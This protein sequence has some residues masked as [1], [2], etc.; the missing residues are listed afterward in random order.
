MVD[1]GG[2]FVLGPCSSWGFC[3]YCLLP[4]ARKIFTGEYNDPGS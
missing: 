2:G 3:W 4:L 1:E